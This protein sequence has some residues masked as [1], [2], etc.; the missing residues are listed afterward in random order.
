MLK[1]SVFR[2]SRRDALRSLGGLGLCIG[3]TAMMAC[4]GNGSNNDA[5][6]SADLE[7]N[8]D[9]ELENDFDSGADTDMGMEEDLAQQ[10]DAEPVLTYGP[11]QEPDINGIQLPA[12]F[13][14]RIVA[15]TGQKP[16]ES[17][18]Y[19]WHGAPDGGAVFATDDG[20]IYLS[21]AELNGK[22]GGVGALRFDNNGNLTSAYA[23]LSGSS[24]NCA[25][26]VMPWGTWLSCEEVEF[27]R[28]WECYPEGQPATL[29]PALGQFKHEAVCADPVRGHLYLTEDEP[30]G[31]L[32][33]FT[34]AGDYEDLSAGNLHVMC[35][36]DGQDGSVEWIDVEDPSAST[37]PT[38]FQSQFSTA[39]DGGEGI[40]LQHDKV[41]F[42]TKGDGRVWEL[43]IVSQSLR[44]F[45]DDDNYENEILNALDGI[46]GKPETNDIL[47]AEDGG[48]MQ[49]VSLNSDGR[50]T[51][52]VQ[53]IGQKSSE[54]TG[55]AFDPSGTRLYFSSQRGFDVD[56]ITYEISGPFNLRT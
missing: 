27:G 28:V 21:N 37:T 7:S 19:I 16:I 34:P 10:S 38:R 32:Y 55:V 12:G 56:G 44:I 42:A 29:L 3:S 26:G 5:A 41:F 20:W 2:T 47:V 31:C 40:C 50:V 1:P 52:V 54:I 14:S 17:S 48:D 45:Y 23:V 46:T 33:R 39:F 22:E 11:L 4:T 36:L 8:L 51:P 24:R 43:D 30:D 53:V 6:A 13:S 15:T 35:V 18:D 9:G 49:I 25:G